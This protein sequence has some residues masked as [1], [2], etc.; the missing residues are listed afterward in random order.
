MEIRNFCCYKSGTDW[1][2]VLKV[3]IISKVLI[4]QEVMAEVHG[5]RTYLVR[6]NSLVLLVNFG[7]VFMFGRVLV[8]WII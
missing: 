2:R 7:C 1:G 6:F 3:K 5:N 8:E 4:L